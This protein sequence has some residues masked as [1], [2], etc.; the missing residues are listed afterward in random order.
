MRLKIPLL[1]T[2]SNLKGDRFFL[3]LQD[4][5]IPRLRFGPSVEGLLLC[6]GAV[7]SSAIEGIGDMDRSRAF[8]RL[9]WVGI[10][11]DG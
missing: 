10:K 4:S 9:A 5:K 7:I 3:V 6:R 8:N 1:R 11:Y 2:A